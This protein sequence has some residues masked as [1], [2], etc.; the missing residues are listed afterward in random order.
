MAE[1]FDME[2]GGGTGYESEN[3]DLSNERQEN[4]VGE[5]L[6]KRS[7]ST[8]VISTKLVNPAQSICKDSCNLNPDDSSELFVR[9]LLEM[10]RADSIL[11]SE[12][13]LLNRLSNIAL[14]NQNEMSPQIQISM[15][16]EL[17][18]LV[19]ELGTISEI[20][21]AVSAKINGCE[22]SLSNIRKSWSSIPVECPLPE[23]STNGSVTSRPLSNGI[24]AA[25]GLENQELPIMKR[26]MT[27]TG[28]PEHPNGGTAMTAK[29]RLSSMTT[30][31]T[32]VP[33]TSC[34]ACLTGIHCPWKA[35]GLPHNF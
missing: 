9:N 31:A 13:E 29:K 15:S 2:A 3:S 25:L 22:I 14:E 24:M 19:E 35:R 10:E 18:Q 21:S 12:E 1:Y 5:H 11:R 27:R 6:L 34:Y 30:A 20:V 4:N 16:M 26:A 17:D 28:K 33:F 23:W 8:C 32:F 7:A